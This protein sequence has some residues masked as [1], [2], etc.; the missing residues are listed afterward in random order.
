MILAYSIVATEEGFYLCRDGEYIIFSQ[1]KERLLAYIEE[2]WRH[3]IAK[4]KEVPYK[5]L[6]TYPLIF[7]E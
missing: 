7:D 5:D 6:K 1:D 2:I 4:T 3:P